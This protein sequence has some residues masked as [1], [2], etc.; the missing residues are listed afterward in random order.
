[1]LAEEAHPVETL[2]ASAVREL[3]S[4]AQSE[5]NSASTEQVLNKLKYFKMR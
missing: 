1:M 5:Y 3:V 4:I 2:D